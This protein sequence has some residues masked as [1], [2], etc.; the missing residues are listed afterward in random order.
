MLSKWTTIINQTTMSEQEKFLEKVKEKL[1]EVIFFE[2]VKMKCGPQNDPYQ[3]DFIADVVF[4]NWK[5]KLAGEI[6]N[7]P[8]SSLFRASLSKL[9]SY[10]MKNQESVPIVV[11]NYLSPQRRE[12]CKKEGIYFLDLS[13]NAFLQYGE[14]L[15]I[16]RTGFPNR[17]PEA[18]KGRNP[19]SDKA[20]LILRA[21]LKKK[22]LWGVRKLG[23][24]IRLDAGYVSRMFR[25]LEKLNYLVKINSKGK[26]KNET[27]ILEDWVHNYDYKKN[28]AFKYFCL[29]K[30]PEKILNRLKNLDIPKNINYAIGFHAGAYL[31]SPHAA[32]N[33]VHIY[34]SSQESMDFFV[35][36]LSLKQVDRGANLILLFPYYKHSIFYDK[37]N[38]K[39]L[40]V[41]SDI[42]LYIDLYK[43]PLRGLEQAEHLYEKRLKKLIESEGLSYG[44]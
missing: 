42:Q 31:V 36:K 18:R 11:A 16:E 4:K 35:N 22:E 8:N 14:G 9:K 27:S 19:F 17:F 21:M 10:V 29:A 32:F 41:S 12:E 37:Q 43:Y 7:Q 20:S 24:N 33:E 28:M 5:F 40:W 30:G 25:E 38:V 6:I 15:Y 13:G 26:L 2:K 39:N 1:K 44:E 34:V 3:P 23:E